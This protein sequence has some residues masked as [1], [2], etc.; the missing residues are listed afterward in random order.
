MS[1]KK[2][3]A[4]MLIGLFLLSLSASAVIASIYNMDDSV[5]SSSQIWAE[6]EAFMHPIRD[7]QIK[8]RSTLG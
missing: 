5:K 6:H 8:N 7:Q 2:R 1:N 4:V 3:L